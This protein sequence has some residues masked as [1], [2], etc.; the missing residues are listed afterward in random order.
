[1]VDFDWLDAD[2]MPRHSKE[3]DSRTSLVGLSRLQ[4]LLRFLIEQ[5]NLPITALLNTGNGQTLQEFPPPPP[6]HTATTKVFSIFTDL[7]K[8]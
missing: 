7:T 5:V 8:S 1:M 6:R 2:A 4:H 3:S